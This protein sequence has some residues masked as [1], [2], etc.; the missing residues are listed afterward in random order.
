[1]LNIGY[2]DFAVANLASVCN[3]GDGFNCTVGNIIS[4]TRLDLYLRQKINH[5]LCSAIEFGM[6]FLSTEAFNFGNRNALHSDIG[7]C[8]TNVV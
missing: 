6:S 7:K 1:M 5:I 3:L 2:E 4:N 8:L